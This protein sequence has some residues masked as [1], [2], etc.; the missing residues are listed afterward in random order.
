MLHHI[1]D[2]GLR[3]QVTS[4]DAFLIELPTNLTISGD[5]LEALVVQNVDVE[6]QKVDSRFWFCSELA[7]LPRK[8]VTEGNNPLTLGDVEQFVLKYLR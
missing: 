3:Y 7:G 5:E 6:E 2:S 1:T 8:V 4:R